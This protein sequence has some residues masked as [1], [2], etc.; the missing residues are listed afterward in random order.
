M[1]DRFLPLTPEETLKRIQGRLG[2]G[3]APACVIEEL[4][5][6]CRDGAVFWAR[7]LAI[8]DEYR[9][10]YPAQAVA[11]ARL[12]SRRA[13]R[14]HRLML[15]EDGRVVE[16]PREG[17]T[18]KTPPPA[19]TF[20]LDVGGEEVR[21][22]Y[23]PGYFPNCDTDVLYFVS[24]HE[25]ARPHALSGTGYHSRFVPHDIIEACG[26]PQAYAALLAAAVLRGEA[27]KLA[28]ALEGPP[29]AAGQ[30]RRRAARPGRAAEQPPPAGEHAAWVIAE[31]EP[32]RNTP[33][34]G[35][36]F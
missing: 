1:S 27:E 12:I 9:P 8:W 3:T 24:P 15:R 28:A 19:L 36:L 29:P 5:P 13:M 33:R 20:R 26:G 21:V 11:L 18:W 34:Q 16:Q 22:E 25:P 2:Q 10:A 23:T 4:L 17:K 35:L 32:P 14:E 30:T 7:C 31:E 6:R